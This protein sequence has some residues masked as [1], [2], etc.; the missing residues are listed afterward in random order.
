MLRRTLFVTL[1]FTALT[2]TACSSSP[3]A[4]LAVDFACTDG[5]SLLVTFAQNSAIVVLPDGY[6]ATLPQQVSGSGFRYAN[7][8]HELRGKGNDITWTTGTRELYC[9]TQK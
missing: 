4:L 5:S 1:I 9:S 6:S 8:R 7:D 2:L 3:K